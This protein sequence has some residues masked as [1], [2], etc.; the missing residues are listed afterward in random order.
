VV[1]VSED[2]WRGA[3]EDEA[4]QDEHRFLWRALLDTIDIDVAGRR[5]LDAGCN[6][7]GFLR[8]LVDE[9]GIAEGYGFDPAS[10][11]IDDARRLAGQRPLTFETADI[12]PAGWAGFDAAFS[13]EVLYLLHDLASHA[14][15]TFAALAPGAPYFAVVGVHARS[16]MMAAWHGSVAGDLGL[17][18]LYDLDELVEAFEGAGF[19]VSAARL[20]V[21]FVPVS[22]RRGG[23]D[24]HQGL[25]DWLDYYERD[26]ILFRF[27]RPPQR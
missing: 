18:R 10:G 9:S 24:H 4:M 13:H 25:A 11:A 19:E 5:V 26:K 12:V 17:P 14:E 23:H 27:T 15:A 3:A 8:L 1:A 16:P 20:R 21:R 2:Y 7:G 6:R 22:S